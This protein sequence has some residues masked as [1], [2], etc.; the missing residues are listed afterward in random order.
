VIKLWKY[1]FGNLKPYLTLIEMLLICI[2]I[3]IQTLTLSYLVVMKELYFSKESTK[4]DKNEENVNKSLR[5][6]NM[7][8]S[9][10]EEVLKLYL[11]TFGI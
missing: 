4:E 5:I 8:M 9:V 10:N 1:G 2:G 7:D 11:F 3:W 6:V